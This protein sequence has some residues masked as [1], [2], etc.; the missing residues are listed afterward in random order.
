MQLTPKPESR[1]RASGNLAQ[2]YTRWIRRKSY[3]FVFPAQRF[4]KPADTS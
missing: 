2:V 3:L 1:V 4:P